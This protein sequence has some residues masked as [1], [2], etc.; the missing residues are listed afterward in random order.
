MTGDAIGAFS[1]E[2]AALL[3]G[4][5]KRQLAYWDRIEFFQPSYA[6]DD[7]SRPFARVYSFRDL[8]ELR[9]L[10]QLRN[11][12]RVK[13]SHLRAVADKLTGLPGSGW[14]SQRLWVVNREVVWRNPNSD[15]REGILD[16]QQVF[17]I[18]LRVVASGMHKA[19]SNLNKRGVDRIG[20][21]VQSK[22]VS[23][24]QPVFSGTRIPISAVRAFLSAGYRTP[25]ILREYPVLAAGDVAAARSYDDQAAVL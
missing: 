18:A 17:D 20:K 8:V 10:H 6:D 14:S 12:Y 24:G 5:S 9:V 1:E 2:Q 25:A 13:M 11:D 19:I 16:R 23:E 4:V 7:R 22:Y 15:R 3:T 21:V